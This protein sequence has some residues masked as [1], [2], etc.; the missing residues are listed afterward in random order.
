M[1][2]ADA[3]ASVVPAGSVRQMCCWSVLSLDLSVEVPVLTV[4]PVS[5]PWLVVLVVLQATS[6]VLWCLQSV[7][8]PPKRCYPAEQDRHILS[9]D[10]P[11]FWLPPVALKQFGLQDES[12]V[13]TSEIHT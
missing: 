13:S 12:S 8:A 7:F 3:K 5:S 6:L 4:M 9:L 11:P 2:A 1:V 10:F